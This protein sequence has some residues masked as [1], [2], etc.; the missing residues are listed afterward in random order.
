MAAVTFAACQKP[1]SSA[2]FG[3]PLPKAL[4]RDKDFEPTPA[5]TMLALY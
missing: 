1:D 2:H 3:L 4:E 5:W